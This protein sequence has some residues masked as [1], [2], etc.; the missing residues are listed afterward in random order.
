MEQRSF[1]IDDQWGIIHYPKQPSGF[2]VLIIG[3]GGHFV[4]NGNSFWLQHPGRKQMLEQLKGHGYTLFTANF[5]G[6]NWGSERAVDLAQKLYTYFMKSEIS[7]A[8]IHILAEGMGG[9]LGL[10]LLQEMP[11]QIRS[12]SL[13]NP[14]L[15]LK[16]QLKKEKENKFF[17]K[18]WLNEVAMAYDMDVKECEAYISSLKEW[19]NFSVVPVHIFHVLGNLRQG[20]VHLYRKIQRQSDVQVSYLLPEKRYMIPY[21]LRTFFKQHEA[22]L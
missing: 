8:K 18:K 21:M 17:Y 12:L 6:A 2:A 11:E 14:C 16:Q 13:I 10:K 7:N 15:S 22:S 3:D 5:Y 19:L 4:E 1:Q 9:L 20:E